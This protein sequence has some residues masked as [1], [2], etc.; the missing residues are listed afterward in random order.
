MTDHKL[1]GR[2]LTVWVSKNGQQASITRIYPKSKLPDDDELE[3][4]ATELSEK[5]DLKERLNR[6]LTE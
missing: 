6:R 5:Y 1:N 3:D 4:I 2:E